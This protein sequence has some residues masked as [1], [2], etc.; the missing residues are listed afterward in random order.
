MNSI[1]DLITEHPSLD[2]TYLSINELVTLVCRKPENPND[3]EFLVGILCVVT[4]KKMLGNFTETDKEINEIE[5]EGVKHML[6]GV[7]H[8]RMILS[9]F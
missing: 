4:L 2:P 8:S 3:Q 6:L 9:T 5:H 1:I 7:Q